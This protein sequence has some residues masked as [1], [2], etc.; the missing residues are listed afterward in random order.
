MLHILIA[1]GRGQAHMA[2]KTV[3]GVSV[4]QSGIVRFNFSDGSQRELASGHSDG[5]ALAVGL[6]ANDQLAE[7]ILIAKAYRHSPDGTA[8]ADV[9]GST[10]TIDTAAEVPIQVNLSAAM[11]G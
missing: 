11:G 7:D 2:V 9:V 6:D 3:T 1:R 8:L 5:V 4:A 10:C